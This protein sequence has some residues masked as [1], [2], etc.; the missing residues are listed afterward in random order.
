MLRLPKPAPVNLPD[1]VRAATWVH[2]VG[3]RPPVATWSRLGGRRDDVET[4]PGPGPAVTIATVGSRGSGGLTF[5]DL[6]SGV[7]H[8]RLVAIDLGRGSG[9]WANTP[10][11]GHPDGWQIMHSAARGGLGVPA[12]PSRGAPDRPDEPVPER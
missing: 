3:N 11:E 1:G 10:L 2:G 5:E 7:G 4:D 6:R 8:L 12:R 9:H